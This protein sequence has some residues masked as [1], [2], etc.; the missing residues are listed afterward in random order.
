MDM[1]S[2]KPRILIVDD[3]PENIWTL[4][5]NLEK[6]YEIMYAASGEEALKV[7]FS[8]EKPD[9]ILLDIIIPGMNGHEVIKR[10]KADDLTRDIPVI[11][12]TAR[13]EEENEIAGFELGAWDYIT[14]PFSMPVVKAR[15]QMVL[16]LKLEMDRRFFL[17]KQIDT[18]N[19]QLENQVRQKEKELRHAKEALEVYEARYRTAFQKT[20]A[21]V[22]TRKKILIVDDNPENIHVLSGS[23]EN[24]YEIMY[25]MDGEDALEIVF[26]GDMPDLI[27]L[28]IMMPG[29]DGYEVCKR[30][31]ANVETRNIPIIF[32]T[33]MRLADDEAKGL[34]LGAIDYISK[35][36]SMS[37][38]KARISTTLRLKDEMNSRIML[39]RQLQGMNQ[40]LENRVNEKVA[41]LRQVNENLKESEN[42]YRSIFENA[43]EGIYQITLEG[44]FLT[45]SPSMAKILGYDSS[46]ELIS[47]VT[48]MAAQCYVNAADREKLFRILTEDGITH[49]FETQM[50]KKDSS[51]IWVSLSVRLIYDDHGQGIYTEG[52]C[53][54]ITRQK[55]AEKALKET[56]Y[57]LRKVQKMEAIGT[58]AGG[59]AHDFNNILFPILGYTEM[60]LEDTPESN[61]LRKSLNGIYSGVLRASDLVKQILTFARQDT[62]ELQLMKMWPIIK[63]ALKLIRAT[64][65]ATINIKQN[66]KTDCGAVKA[67]PTQIHQIVMNLA[68]NAY[69][70][71]GS[72][73]GELKVSLEEVQLD[74]VHNITQD[75]IKPGVYACLTIADTGCGM[76]KDVLQKIF[77]PF[78]TTKEQG[79]GTGMGLSLVYGIVKNM[80]GTIQVHSEPGKGSEF[81]VYIPIV[82]KTSERQ[83]VIIEKKIQ[84]GTEHM[85]L[86]DDEDEIVNM[87][88]QMLERMG[89]KVTAHTSSIKALEIFRAEPD[90]FD[91][92]ITDMAMP[93]M[94]GDIFA[95]ELT[96]IRPDI[97]ILLCTGFSESMSEE[98]AMSLGIKGFLMKPISKTDLAEK[99]HELLD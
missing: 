77:D 13:A 45:A 41:E 39:S 54:D 4:I 12:L 92:V 35:P 69:H 16:D 18:L 83:D 32:I 31:K 10:L 94:G 65:P 11:F 90:K 17:K 29:L 28:D 78:F 79:R 76:H 89:Y 48:D 26:S 53:T 84:G 87:T 67:D 19:L 6:D 8:D 34:R 95:V 80:N 72:N 91:M 96:G 27:L 82:K 55:E 81:N 38:V 37:V 74:E 1:K 44:R 66:I 43:V 2:Q 58:L 14:K 85:L 63:E 23:L 24:N 93:N 60:L 68:T 7:A 75:I 30:F 86:V 70:A 3:T 25:A 57:R 97:P 22:S 52:V 42:R 51:I 46:E 61:P 9:V 64:I 71:M 99:I 49:G 98:K 40:D 47:S 73:G 33:A 36:F 15:L 88:K 5:E 20:G 50:K 59:I 56:E 21:S 62:E